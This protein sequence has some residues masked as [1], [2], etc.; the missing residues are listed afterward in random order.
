MTVGGDGGMVVT[1]DEGLAD[2]VAKLRDCGRKSHYEHDVIGYTFRLN[3]AN[4]AI[5]LVQLKYLDAWNS[6]RRHIAE[7]YREHLSELEG[8]DLLETDRKATPCYHIFPIRTQK[9]DALRS[10]LESKEV[11]TG[12]HYPIPI[13]LQ[14]PYRDR[15]GF[16]EGDY[17]VAERVSRTTLSLPMFPGLEDDQAK[18]ICEV[19]EEFF[20]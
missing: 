8:I 3:T 6:H 10:Y 14:R 13:H 7:I 15:F 18:Y 5:G 16:S 19:I 1:S 20:S 17:P 4:A 11:Q 2:R 12:I 9:R